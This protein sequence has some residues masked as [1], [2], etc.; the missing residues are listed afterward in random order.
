MPD[1]AVE[2]ASGQG[3]LRPPSPL[4]PQFR[5]PVLK[6]RA[7]PSPHSACGWLVRAGLGPSEF[8]DSVPIRDSGRS[9]T[10]SGTPEPTGGPGGDRGAW[11]VVATS[12][13]KF[14]TGTLQPTL[15]HL[16]LHDNLPPMSINISVV[17]N[18]TEVLAALR[19]NREEHQTIVRE[20]REGYMRDARMAVLKRL[21]EL[22]S[23]KLVAL[24]FNL[25]LPQDFTK[26]YDTAIR[27][28]ELHTG[29]TVSLDEEMV[30]CLVLN[31]WGWMGSFLRSNSS[32]SGTARG[33]M[34]E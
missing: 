25:A 30:R 21:D 2:E 9:R 16:C 26:E 10:R 29:E 4:L 14:R 7:H 32:Y 31:E 1:E 34:S 17:A 3:P 28:L 18:K 20:A 24:S 12:P 22:D 23:G 5:D 15:R 27:M 8:L 33:K 13:R 6:P 19:V 11:R